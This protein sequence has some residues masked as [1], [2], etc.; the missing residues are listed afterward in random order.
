MF[1]LSN[2]LFR[3]HPIIN[4]TIINI[5]RALFVSDLLYGSDSWSTILADLR[6]L[7][8][9]NMR[10]QRRLLCMFWQ[11]HISNQSI[12]EHTKQPTASYGRPLLADCQRSNPMKA[13]KLSN[14]SKFQS[15]Q[16]FYC[17]NEKICGSKTQRLVTCRSSNVGV[18]IQDIVDVSGNERWKV[19]LAHIITDAGFL[20]KY[21]T[22]NKRCQTG[23]CFTAPEL[24]RL[25]EESERL[26]ATT[27]T[28]A[29]P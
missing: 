23:N 10:G 12:H 6:R 15:E 2:P 26:V 8:M 9:F 21:I 14:S 11:Q 22:Y 5:Y 20:S 4:I 28:T 29:R 19:N 16:C 25:A 13:L 27:S 1:G 24:A 3:K 17:Q 7:D 18:S